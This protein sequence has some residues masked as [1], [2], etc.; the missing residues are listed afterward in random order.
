M[1]KEMLDNDNG[2]SC[3]IVELPM[4]SLVKFG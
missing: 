4:K 3:F 1:R 2:S